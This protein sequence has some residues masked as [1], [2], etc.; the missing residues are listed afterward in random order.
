VLPPKVPA[1]TLPQT[2]FSAGSRWAG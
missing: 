2:I 1:D